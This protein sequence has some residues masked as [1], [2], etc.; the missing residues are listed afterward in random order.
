MSRLKV[1]PTKRNLLISAVVFAV[2]IALFLS[3]G[4]VDRAKRLYYAQKAEA[5]LSDEN[6]KLNE[7]L[8][9]L[10][11]TNIEGGNATCQYMEIAEYSRNTLECTAELKSYAV[12][13]DESSKN[14]AITASENLSKLLVQNGWQQGQYEVS[15]WF[16]DVL[17]KVDYNPDAY[18]YKYFGKTFCVLD[19]FV[20]YSNPSPP[21]VNVLFRCTTPQTEPPV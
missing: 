17:N 5:S 13:S 8:T 10:G 21:A 4:S 18:H 16:K 1:R 19:F 9:A 20:A 14:K 3:L 7:P 2:F 6:K 15:K 12:F 11:F